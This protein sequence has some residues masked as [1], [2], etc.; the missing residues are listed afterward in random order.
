MLI[1]IQNDAEMKLV[2]KLASQLEEKNLSYRIVTPYESQRNLI[3]TT[4]QENE[5]QWEDKCF[6]VDSF[7]GK[8]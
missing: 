4:M 7:Q 3:E 5:M 1:Y 2:L 8:L 6:N